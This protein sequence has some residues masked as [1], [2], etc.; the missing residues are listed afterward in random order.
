MGRRIPALSASEARNWVNLWGWKGSVSVNQIFEAKAKAQKRWEVF[1]PKVWKE[2]RRSK[3][4][5]SLTWE[6]NLPA[7]GSLPTA[8]DQLDLLLQHLLIVASSSSFNEQNLQQASLPPLC[9]CQLPAVP[10]A[11]KPPSR[12]SSPVRSLLSFKKHTHTPSF[13]AKS[14]VY[15]GCYIPQSSYSRKDLRG[16]ETHLRRVRVVSWDLL[17]QSTYWYTGKVIGGRKLEKI[18]LEQSSLLKRN[19]VLSDT[20]EKLKLNA[21]ATKIHCS[22]FQG[23]RSTKQI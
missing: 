2:W 18:Y 23:K 9:C 15:S 1:S 8:Q 10:H 13:S 4:E 19:S 6:E 11:S 5:F 21:R 7:E 22:L 20:A 14:H 16:Q 17:S 12:P 3:T